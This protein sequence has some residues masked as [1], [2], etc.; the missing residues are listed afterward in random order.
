[1]GRARRNAVA[2]DEGE[3]ISAKDAEHAPDGGSNQAL[4][5]H[6]AQPPL[7][8]DDGDADQQT[9]GGCKV[10]G[11]VKRTNKKAND[12]DDDDK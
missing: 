1:L 3:K 4:Q 8:R 10:C 6:R 9:D 7:E 2:N 5:A 11:Q 12:T